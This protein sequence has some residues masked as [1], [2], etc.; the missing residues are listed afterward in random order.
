VKI[1]TIAL[2]LLALLAFAFNSVLTRLALGG[3]EIGAAAFAA[4][5][6]VSGA[7]MLAAWTALRARNARRLKRRSRSAWVRPQTFLGPLMLF[8]Y[9]APFSF[10]YLRI[11]AAVGAL[12]LFGI[13][14]FT[15]IGYGLM[16]GERP[17]PL[18]WGGT[19]LAAAGLL[20]LVAPKVSRPDTLGVVLMAVAG[21]AWGIYSIVGRGAPEAIAANAANFVWTAPLVLILAFVIPS[22]H[23]ATTRGI[24]LAVLSGAITS[25]LGYAIWYRA[26]RS[27]TL[28]QAAVAQMTVPVIAAA[29][30]VLLLHEAVTGRLA[31]SATI[32]LAGFA[33]V[34]AG[35]AR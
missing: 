1:R 13:V 10:A 17:S 19:F 15:M 14:Q 9:V 33:M 21:I 2:T 34:L 23:P 26:V 7:V 30:A 3:Q 31:V 6:I 29:A 24:L 11:G 12:V 18:A 8:A 35:R 16:R 5:R 25:G 20:I 22:T 28:Q 4:I 27:L 32:V